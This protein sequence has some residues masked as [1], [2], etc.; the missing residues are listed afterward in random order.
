[1]KE[2]K[3]H[4]NTWNNIL[5]SRI[6]RLNIVNMTIS[7]RLIQR[8]NKISIKI[9]PDF[10]LS[11]IIWQPALKIQNTWDN[12]ERQ[13]SIWRTPIFKTTTNEG[14]KIIFSR[15]SARE[16]EHL[17]KRMSLDPYLI[18]YTKINSQWIKGL[19]TRTELQN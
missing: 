15:N 2:I 9:L 19:N 5:C 14:E 13:E 12:L 1:M 11:F 8:F 4:L 18:S 16:T 3:E 7:I 6:W 10:F 17:N